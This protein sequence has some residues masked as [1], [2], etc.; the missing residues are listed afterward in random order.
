MYR[1]AQGESGIW[2]ILRTA[3]KAFVSNKNLPKCLTAVGML[4]IHFHS[5][6]FYSIHFYSRSFFQDFFIPFIF[7]PGLFFRTFMWN[8]TLAF[9]NSPQLNS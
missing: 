2:E 5:K 1:K 7:I 6:T 4:A 3:Q 8:E 9:T